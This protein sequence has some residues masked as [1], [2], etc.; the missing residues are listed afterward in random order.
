MGKEGEE[1][2]GEEMKEKERREGTFIPY[3]NSSY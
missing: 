2:R 1:D 3:I